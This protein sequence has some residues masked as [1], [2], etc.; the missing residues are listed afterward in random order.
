MTYLL[1]KLKKIFDLIFWYFK[2]SKIRNSKSNNKS[3]TLI[4]S[5]ITT[6]LATVKMN[7]ILAKCFESV[8][9][10]IIII[11]RHKQF[12]YELYYKFML[13]RQKISLFRR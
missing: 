4:I 11:F 9:Y 1:D 2:T 12:L 8:G 3:K 5:E 7:C 10:E 13:K 6:S